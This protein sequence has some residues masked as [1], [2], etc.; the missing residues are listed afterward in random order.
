MYSYIS[1]VGVKIAI[2]DTIIDKNR[3]ILV[4][5]YDMSNLSFLGG[6][7]IALFAAALFVYENV[8]SCWYYI[9]TIL[10]L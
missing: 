7:Y 2:I 4:R 10:T 8:F 9:A 1:C 5:N 3:Q 6:H